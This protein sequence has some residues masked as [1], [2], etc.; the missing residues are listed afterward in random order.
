[1]RTVVLALVLLCSGALLVNLAG[2]QPPAN[3]LR[4]TVCLR[5]GSRLTGTCAPQPLTLVT[6]YARLQVAL[7]DVA[8]LSVSDDRE[9]V[10]LTTRTGDQLTGACD[11]RE[12]TLDSLVGKVVVPIEHLAR[13]QVGAPV[14]PGKP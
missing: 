5:D 14:S 3:A 1:M 4:V 9:M 7:G 13:L 8:E 12:L 2:E 10:K 6:A 11:L